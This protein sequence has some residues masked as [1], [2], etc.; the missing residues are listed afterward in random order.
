MAGTGRTRSTVPISR[1]SSSFLLLASMYSFICASAEE[2]HSTGPV[3]LS[4]ET[5]NPQVSQLFSS[6]ESRQW[7]LRHHRVQRATTRPRRP[8]PALGVKRGDEGGRASG[9]LKFF[10]HL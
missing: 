5:L 3:G 2:A 7:R 4:P 10:I 6:D 9:G 8:L 1:S